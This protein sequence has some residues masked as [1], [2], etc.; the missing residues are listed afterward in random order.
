MLTHRANIFAL[1]V[2]YSLITRF[3]QRAN[4]FALAVSVFLSG[5]VV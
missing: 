1:V 2:F 3:F 5:H 4:V